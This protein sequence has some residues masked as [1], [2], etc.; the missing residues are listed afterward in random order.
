MQK[1]REAKQRQLMKKEK[2]ESKIQSE[3]KERK[4]KDTK[5]VRGR[6]LQEL[7]KSHL[8]TLMNPWITCPESPE[9]QRQG[10]NNNVKTQREAGRDKEKDAEK[11]Q[12]RKKEQREDTERG[13]DKEKRCRQKEGRNNNVKTKKR[14]RDKEKVCRR[15]KNERDACWGIV[16]H[17]LGVCCSLRREISCFTK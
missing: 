9:E 16:S 8:V 2:N 10:R 7:G 6:Q 13:R 11:K 14:G 1:Q 4:R 12:G 17:F 3:G 15:T 5:E